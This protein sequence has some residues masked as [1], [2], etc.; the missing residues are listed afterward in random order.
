MPRAALV[1]PNEEFF[2]NTVQSFTA[3][4]TRQVRQ[5]YSCGV[6]GAETDRYGDW[7][8][9]DQT[10]RHIGTEGFRLCQGHF[11][12]LRNRKPLLAKGKRGRVVGYI[13]TR[14]TL[15]VNKKVLRYSRS[16]MATELATDR[17]IVR[18]TLTKTGE[19]LVEY[20]R[21]D[22][23]STPVRVEA[24]PAVV[25]EVVEAAPED[26]KRD[27]HRVF[28]TDWRAMPDEVVELAEASRTELAG[29][30]PAPPSAGT[31]FLT[32][33]F[34]SAGVPHDALRHMWSILESGRPNTESYYF[35]PSGYWQ[36]ER[37]PGTRSVRV[38]FNHGG[39]WDSPGYLLSVRSLNDLAAGLYVNL[40]ERMRYAPSRLAAALSSH[41]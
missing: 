37:V 23:W 19:L 12:L 3:M 32:R 9:C 24:E 15:H 17:T 13:S 6:R 35:T 18:A 27:P 20:C 33:E 30:S 7:T 25:E 40:E 10:A 31:H 39:R 21:D 22:V 4:T 41:A 2:D 11:D 8:Y 36:M 16:G 29:T 5:E 1:Q 34:G 28:A 38:D 14:N 26:T